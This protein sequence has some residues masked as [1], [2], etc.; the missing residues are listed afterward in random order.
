MVYGVI[1]GSSALEN[2][3]LSLDTGF[4][5]GKKVS[6]ECYSKNKS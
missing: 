5:T 2:N 6:V 4:R 3:T 1:N